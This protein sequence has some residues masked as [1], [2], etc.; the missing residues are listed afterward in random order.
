MPTREP[1]DEGSEAYLIICRLGEDKKLS[2]YAASAQGGN[3]VSD[4]R[5]DAA[6]RALE[7]VAK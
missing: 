2:G 3:D 1:R 5:A 6:R 4:T 7:E